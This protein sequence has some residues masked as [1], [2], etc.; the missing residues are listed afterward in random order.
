MEH[1]TVRT[2][3]EGDSHPKKFG[4]DY[5]RGNG[6]RKTITEGE[7]SS[8][9]AKEKAAAAVHECEWEPFK[10]RGGGLMDVGHGWLDEPEPDSD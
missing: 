6:D 8:Q 2:Y 10:D 5:T 7:R 1:V 9:I 4:A 3:R